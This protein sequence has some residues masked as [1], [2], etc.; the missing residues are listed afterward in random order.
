MAK[1]IDD[2]TYLIRG[3]KKSGSAV[4]NFGD[5]AYETDITDSPRTVTSGIRPLTAGYPIAKWGW[6]NQKPREIMKLVRENHIKPQLIRTERDFVMGTKLALFKILPSDSN[7]TKKII[8]ASDPE[9]E[10][11]GDQVGLMEYWYKVCSNFVHSHN[12]PNFASLSS[13]TQKVSTIDCI[14]FTEARAELKQ[15]GVVNNY[16]LHPDWLL[17]ARKSDIL[18]KPAYDPANPT[19]F[20]SFMHWVKDYIPGQPYYAYPAW[21]GT[22]KWTENSNLIPRYHNAGLTNGYNIKYFISVPM[23]YVQ[24]LT[25]N[26]QD[27]KEITKA[28]EQI[29]SEMDSWLA[30]VDNADKAIVTFSFMDQMGKSIP[31]MKIDSLDN[32]GTEAAYLNLDKAANINQASGHGIPLSLA[33]IDTGSKLG[34]SGSELRIAYDTHIALRTPQP[35]E[36]CLYFLNKVVM[37]INGWQDKGTFFGVEDARITTLETNPTGTQQVVNQGQQG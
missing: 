1:Q 29:T 2:N 34:G 20:G 3:S 36:R 4:V 33:S 21:W 25:S 35:R 10:D 14:D 5:N 22:E 37:K 6:N 19:R 32:K 13:K 16:Y 8:P 9:M 27:P 24:S 11:W 15:N 7:E 26:T 12:I 28:K 18:I 23:Q 17:N 30:G 31:G